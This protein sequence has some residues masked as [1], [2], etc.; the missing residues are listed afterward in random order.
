MI[1]R[2]SVMPCLRVSDDPALEKA[3]LKR[4]VD[5]STIY[6]SQRPWTFLI[7]NGTPLL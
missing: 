7:P 3:E 4:L 6:F 1:L 2:L 5:K